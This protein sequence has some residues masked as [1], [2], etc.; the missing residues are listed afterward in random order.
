MEG[1]LLG[2]VPPLASRHREPR[3]QEETAQDVLLPGEVCRVLGQVLKARI[4]RCVV[5]SSEHFCVYHVQT[6]E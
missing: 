3:N 4:L 6:L 2:T 1:P 5:A